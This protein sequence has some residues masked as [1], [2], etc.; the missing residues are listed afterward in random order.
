M[1]YVA[2]NKVN[3]KILKP[4]IKRLYIEEQMDVTEICAMHPGAADSTIY[5]WIRKEKWNAL[6]DEKMK[7]FIKSP[8]ILM[9]MLEKMIEGLGESIN[10]PVALAKSADAIS[11]ITKSIKSLIKEKDRLGSILFA[12]GELA[13]HMN[14]QSGQHIY[15][16]EFRDKFDKLLSTFQEKMILKYSPKNYG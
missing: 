14:E 13:K 12:T 2:T 3:I 6:R 15:D 7:K 11:K 1:S 8:E 9:N 5:T 10:D 16:S 4:E